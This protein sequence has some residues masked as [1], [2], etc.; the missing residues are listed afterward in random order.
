M[1]R[2]GLQR[3]VGGGAD[4]RIPTAPCITQGHDFGMGAAC[5]LGS[6]MPNNST[7]WTNQNATD[8]RIGGSTEKTFLSEHEC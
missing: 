3:D 2:T 6:A 4:H 1:V 8:S 5:K 7:Y